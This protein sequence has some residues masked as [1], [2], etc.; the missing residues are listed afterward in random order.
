MSADRAHKCAIY[1]RLSREDADRAEESESIANQRAL[2]VKYASERG[3][4][5]CGVYCDEDYSGADAERPAFL[6]M[7]EGAEAGHFNIVLCKTQSRFT[8]DMEL[9]EKLIHRA[10]PL[11]GVRFVAACD[12]ADTELRG[13]KKARQI[14][15]LVNEWYLEDLSDNI[16]MVLDHKRSE[17]Q[18]IGG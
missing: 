14:N 1:C 12:G 17:G 3:W 9:V 15:G 6:R 2:L 10:F 11:W 4:E 18:Y 13:N 7:L 8:R 5:I 16:R